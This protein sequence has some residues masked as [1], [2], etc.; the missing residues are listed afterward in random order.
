MHW[1]YAPTDTATLCQGDVLDRTVF[2]DG[3][4]AQF[5]PYYTAA[6]APYLMVLTQSCD[7]VRRPNC[8]AEYITVCP[9]RPLEV[10]LTRELAALIARSK[11]SA[12]QCVDG[13]AGP[14]VSE[15]IRAQFS[16]AVERLLNNNHGSYFFLKADGAAGV[17]VDACAFL[18]VCFTVRASHYSDVLHA[19]VGQLA[20]VF[21]AKL[22]DLVGEI[23]SRVGTE[24]WSEDEDRR[25]V[26]DSL[27]RRCMETAEW[28]P[29]KLFDAAAGAV[30][31]AGKELDEAGFREAL[32]APVVQQKLRRNAALAAIRRLWPPGAG[33]PLLA[34][35]QRS[36]ENDPDFSRAVK[37]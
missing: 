17:P 15:S 26:Y 21:Q 6:R 2:I 9:I 29:H 30:A 3:L 37:D 27:H 36:L 13:S 1:T 31:A 22:G 34:E 11:R 5:H 18:H 8:N 14:I 20:S 19:K 7:L 10:A 23:Y 25:K 16:M 24:D 32:R 33:A 12:P 4:L 35:F 28:V